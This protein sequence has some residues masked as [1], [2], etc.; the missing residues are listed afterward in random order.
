MKEGPRDEQLER[1]AT[2]MGFTGKQ[3]LADAKR[4]M[5]NLYK[6]FM[7]KDST[8]VEINPLVETHDGRVL[9]ADAKLNFDD[10]ASYR[11][12]DIFALR[13]V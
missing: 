12:K 8:L 13:Y 9:C 1:L 4:V 2:A 3:Q 6:L 7:E 11:Q 10:N 5:A